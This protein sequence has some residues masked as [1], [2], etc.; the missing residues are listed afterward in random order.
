MKAQRTVE[1]LPL[2][3]LQDDERNPKDHD[4]NTIDASLSRF[5]VLDLIVQDQRTGKIVSGH[6][7][8]HTLEGMQAR[9][10]Q[11]P[12][13][14]RVDKN[15]NWLVP[16]VTGWA[17]QNDNEAAAALIAMNRT[18]ELGGWVDDA[19]LE[20]LAELGDDELLGTG[21]DAS[22]L[23]ALN[24]ALDE[25]SWEDYTDEDLDAALQESDESAY[26]VLRI[27]VAP[28]YVEA[29]HDNTKGADDS[30]RFIDLL[31]QAGAVLDR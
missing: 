6:G 24:A 14:V 20:L 21:Y 1:Y 19:L 27:Q 3:S 9:G 13:G 16:V 12:E 26:P 2:S 31:E 5:G 17:S 15:G 28:E 23:D 7:R 8:K 11:P 18:T 4:I 25:H 29:F 22:D 30:E 10:E